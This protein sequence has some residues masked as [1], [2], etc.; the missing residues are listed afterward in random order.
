M[1]EKE[2]CRS[3]EIIEIKK[4]IKIVIHYKE[5]EIPFFIQY[6][7]DN[8]QIDLDFCKKKT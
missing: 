7:D 4:N 1:C 8:I 3:I 6:W 5:G 2:F